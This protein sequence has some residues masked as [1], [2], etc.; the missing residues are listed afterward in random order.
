MS[1]S[2]LVIG[3]IYA[4]HHASVESAYAHFGYAESA[5]AENTTQEIVIEQN[6]ICKEVMFAS[7]KSL[8]SLWMTSEEE[9][10]W[11]DL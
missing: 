1:D 2:T 10:A 4:P 8:V 11:K 3:T 5:F 9:E 7:E 6:S